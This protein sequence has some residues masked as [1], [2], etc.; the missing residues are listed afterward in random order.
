MTLNKATIDLV[1]SFEGLRL[2]AYRDSAG[3]LTIGYGTTAAAG[4]GITPVPGMRI[5]EAGAESL[6][7]EGL[8]KFAAQI[9]PLIKVPV[10]AN[11]FGACV[12]LAYN[13]GPGAFGKSTVL[14]RLNA[15]DRAGAAEAFAMWDKAG[16]HVLPGLVRRRKAE[17]ALF[18]TPDASPA[19]SPSWL[20]ALIA[21]IIAIFRKGQ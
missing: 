16:G 13:I 3:V 7:A 1:K 9:R 20:A 8:A 5:T 19:P 4:L 17:A 12:S 11:E 21:A 15:G 14:R 18:L 6:L 10:N 2:E